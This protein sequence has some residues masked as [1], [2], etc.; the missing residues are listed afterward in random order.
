M[1]CEPVVSAVCL[2]KKLYKQAVLKLDF[3]KIIMK[4]KWIKSWGYVSVYTK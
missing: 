3:L 2:P 4:F 1:L